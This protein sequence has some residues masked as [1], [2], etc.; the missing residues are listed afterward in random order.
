M[1]RGQTERSLADETPN[2]EEALGFNRLSA[3]L[4]G[5]RL[6]AAVFIG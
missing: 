6:V 3:A 5:F 4:F 2:G 1:L